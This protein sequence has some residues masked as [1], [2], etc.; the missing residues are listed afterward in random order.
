MIGGYTPLVWRGFGAVKDKSGGSFIFS[1]TN[2]HKF[3]LDME[4]TAIFR[5]ADGP[6]FGDMNPDF[7]IS[8]EGNKNDCYSRINRSYNNKNYIKCNE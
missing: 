8:N 3:V 2:N 4:K 1:L 5:G 6:S 7:S